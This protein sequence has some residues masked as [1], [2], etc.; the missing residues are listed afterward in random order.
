MLGIDGMLGSRAASASRVGKC[1][2]GNRSANPAA[3]LAASCRATFS[4]VARP[5]GRSLRTTSAGGAPNSH[6][7]PSH[8]S[9]SSTYQVG[10]N[11]YHRNPCRTDRW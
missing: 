8:D 5:S 7:T 3:K 9:A 10:S 4:S 6:T 2:S 11:S 1:A